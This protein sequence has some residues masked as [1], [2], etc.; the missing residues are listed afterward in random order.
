MRLVDQEPVNHL[1]YLLEIAL[2]EGIQVCLRIN[3]LASALYADSGAYHA[4]PFPG[5]YGRLHTEV[6]HLAL[7]KIISGCQEH[8]GFGR[9]HGAIAEI[10][11]AFAVHLW[12][13]MIKIDVFFGCEISH[14]I[15]IICDGGR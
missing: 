2:S 8:G 12:N 1:P 6:A 11:F 14:N 4:L 9:P 5:V 15:P 13:G 10:Q 3:P 7:L